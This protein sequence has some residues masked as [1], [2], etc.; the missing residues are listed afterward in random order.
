MSRRRLTALAFA[1]PL[2]L[3]LGGCSS[4]PA[5]RDPAPAGAATPQFCDWARAVIDATPVLPV[6]GEDEPLDIDRLVQAGA[7]LNRFA[8]TLSTAATHAPTQRQA[9]F[10][11]LADFNRSVAEVIAGEE[12]LEQTQLDAATDAAARVSQTMADECGLAFDP[13]GGLAYTAGAS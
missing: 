3:A 2:A 4:T 6:I 13:A 10:T 7:R 1:L 12:P 9:D 11:F 5:E 8:D